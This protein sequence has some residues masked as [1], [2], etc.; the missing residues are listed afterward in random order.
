[1]FSESE[2]FLRAISSES[3]I[4]IVLLKLKCSKGL[5]YLLLICKVV[6]VMVLASRFAWR[7]SSALARKDPL[8][9][10]PLFV[11]LQGTFLVDCK[12]PDAN[13]I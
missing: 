13:S 9:L 5:M 8:A 7:T 1:M 12:M 6:V 11:R 10:L 2:S 4:L 3:G